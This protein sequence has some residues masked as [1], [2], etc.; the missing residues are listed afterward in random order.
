MTC[1]L[2]VNV[3]TS[4]NW[5]KRVS[6]LRL[7]LSEFYIQLTLKRSPRQELISVPLTMSLGGQ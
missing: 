2:V 3:L 1:D 4:V 5:V 6:V 7:S